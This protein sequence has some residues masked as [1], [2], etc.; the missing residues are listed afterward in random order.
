MS[1]GNRPLPHAT[2]VR[3]EMRDKEKQTNRKSHA[4]GKQTNNYRKST[5]RELHIKSSDMI[6]II[7]N[8]QK[9]LLLPVADARIISNLYFILSAAH[10][11]HADGGA[12]ATDRSAF[13][14]H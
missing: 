3:H 11:H 2:F 5:R 6:A 10:A 4:L 7:L 13:A 14:L 12:L 8:T 1:D 9:S